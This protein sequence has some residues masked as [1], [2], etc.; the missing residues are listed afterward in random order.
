MAVALQAE[1]TLVRCFEK[2]PV[3]RQAQREELVKAIVA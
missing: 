1:Q 3:G 2:T